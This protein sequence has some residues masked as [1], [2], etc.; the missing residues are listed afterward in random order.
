[1]PDSI[2]QHQITTL[3][4]LKAIYGEPVGNSLVKEL[5]HVSDHYR[6]FIEASPFVVLATAGPDGLDCTPR[7]DPPGFVRVEGRHTL[8]IPDRRGNNRVDSLRN[9]VTDPRISLLFLIPGVGET[10]RVNGRAVI[11]TD[12]DLC[13]SFAMADKLP[14]SVIV[15]TAERV[16]FQCPKALVRSRLW[17]PSR[18]VD[19]RSLPSTGEILAAIRPDEI[20]ADAL[21]RAYPERL[22]QTIY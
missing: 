10:L 2:E 15:V 18:H 4:Q 6:A 3:E 12:P 22:K 21:D 19:R 16:Y 7:G 5:D 8:M 9:L 11:S 17:D 1:M 20:D 14:R 13:R